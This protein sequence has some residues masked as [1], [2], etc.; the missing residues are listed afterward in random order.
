MIGLYL[1]L[2]SNHLSF[3]MP[4]C[5]DYGPSPDIRPTPVR[6]VTFDLDNTLWRTGKTIQA[7]NDALAQ[8]LEAEHN[9]STPVPIVMKEL[10]SDEKYGKGVHLT[11]L[12]KD[13]IE[14]I[15]LEEY[16]ESDQ[17]KSVAE[18]AFEVW[19]AARHE[20]ILHHLADDV[21]ASL[22]RIKDAGILI[23]AITDGNS[24]PQRVT[25]VGAF[26]DFCVHAETVGFAKPDS[27]VFLHAA[28]VAQRHLGEK[29]D[30]GV[31]MEA[32]MGPFWVHVGDDFSKDVAG[33]KAMNLRTVWARELIQDKLPPRE[34]EPKNPSTSVT[35]LIEAVSKQSVT[36]MALGAEDYL[37]NGLTSEFADSTVDTFAEISDVILKWHQEGTEGAIEPE[38]ET[39]E[40]SLHDPEP[41][42]SVASETEGK[43][44]FCMFCGSKIPMEA[45][46]CPSCGAK[47]P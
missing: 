41:I 10:G 23:G 8:Y 43:R 38:I 1:T 4:F 17:A 31:N 33:A 21:V 19:S 45:K 40:V 20:A 2:L 13:A 46:F 14:R 32:W 9:I 25:D 29:L 28:E 36:R 42:D 44:L 15:H 6:I 27:R 35:G 3:S 5:R 18:K 34:E 30:D 24:D 26:F 22:Q 12:R 37:A 7:A 11:Q 16:N 39:K 47:L